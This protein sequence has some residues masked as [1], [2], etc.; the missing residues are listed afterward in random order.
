MTLK[1]VF[2]SHLPSSQYVFKKG[3][4]AIFV[5]GR[6]ETDNAEFIAELM[7]EVQGNHPHIF[8]DPNERTIDSDLQEKIRKAQAEAVSR[9]LA[10]SKQEIEQINNAGVEILS[11]PS[12][13]TPV[14]ATPVSVPNAPSN[15]AS[16]LGQLDGLVVGG[17]VPQ[18][19]VQTST[20]IASAAAGQ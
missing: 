18:T 4:T 7:Q 8:V 12:V 20:D 2:K 10:E 1:T 17:Q 3:A 19:V 14:P 11:A 13:A 15:V 6:Y 9:V 5:R 16:I